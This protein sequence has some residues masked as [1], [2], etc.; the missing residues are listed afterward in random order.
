MTPKLACLSMLLLAPAASAH[1]GGHGFGL[2]ESPTH[3]RV[4]A[5]VIEVKDA[6]LGPKAAMIYKAELIRWDDGAMRVYLY[7]KRMRALDISTFDKSAK[8]VLL[9]GEK[10]AKKMPFSMS[11]EEG[12]FI[13]KA[14]KAPSRPFNIEIIFKEGK[15]ALMAAFENLD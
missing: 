7:D 2:E 8:A 10:K 9:A 12:S 5:S 1:E 15:Q 3:S 14:P 6:K 11:R 13:G 4:I